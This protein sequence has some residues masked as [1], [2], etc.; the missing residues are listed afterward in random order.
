MASAAAARS[1]RGLRCCARS[2]IGRHVLRGWDG[3]VGSVSAHYASYAVAQIY[4]MEE[5]WQRGSS[6]KEEARELAV[7][8]VLG[9]DGTCR[10]ERQGRRKVID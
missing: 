2:H 7:T 6:G 8:A 10:R 9:M 4:A 1:T 3:I 5:E